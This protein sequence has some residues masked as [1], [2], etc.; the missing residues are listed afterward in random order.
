MTII[1]H[2]KTAFFYE[3]R[4]G[5]CVGT[6]ESQLSFRHKFFRANHTV[7]KAIIDKEKI[8]IPLDKLKTD[9]S[10][11]TYPLISYVKERIKAKIAEN[12][13]L[14]SFAATRT[15]MN[16]LDSLR[17]SLGGNHQPGLYNQ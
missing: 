14:R 10:N 15:A 4:R 5:D 7:T 17:P 1:V 3:M 9:L 8:Y 2:F 16:G 12:K 6:R 11:R 13:E